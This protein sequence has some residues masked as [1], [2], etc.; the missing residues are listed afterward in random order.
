MYAILL[1]ELSA[2]AILL[3]DCHTLLCARRFFAGYYPSQ[4]SQ[5]AKALKTDHY[6][7]VVIRL[8]VKRLLIGRATGFMY[9]EL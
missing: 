6:S 2:F 4:S 7:C 8:Q 3:G 9:A 1:K 5:H